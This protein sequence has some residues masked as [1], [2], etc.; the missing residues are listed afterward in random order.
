MTNRISKWSDIV[1]DQSLDAY[2]VEHFGDKEKFR[3]SKR[4]YRAGEKTS[5][6]MV[7]SICFILRG[8]CRYEFGGLRVE[9]GEGEC[10]ELPEGR[11]SFEVIDNSGCEAVLVMKIP[12]D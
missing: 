5:G 4:N 12:R 10:I 7:S 1:G 8:K 11:H 9:L 3:I 2:V 6:G